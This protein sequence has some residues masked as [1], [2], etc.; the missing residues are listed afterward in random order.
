MCFEV[1][2]GA[3]GITFHRFKYPVQQRVVGQEAAQ[4]VKK[5]MKATTRIMHDPVLAECDV[6]ATVQASSTPETGVC[7]DREVTRE[8]QRDVDATRA[9][10]ETSRINHIYQVLKRRSRGG[11]AGMLPQ[12][13]NPSS[14]ASRR[15]TS[16]ERQPR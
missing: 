13:T 1:Q 6:R 15:Y 3:H 14:D 10:R 12:S 11:A 2:V 8:A 16:K 4:R 5:M 7:D 9:R